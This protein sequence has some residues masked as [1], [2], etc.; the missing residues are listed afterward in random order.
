MRRKIDRKAKH[1][2]K[3]LHVSNSTARF[4]LA[5]SF[6]WH[7]FGCSRSFHLSVQL[8]RD[9]CWNKKTKQKLLD[10]AGFF[11][12]GRCVLFFTGEKV[13]KSKKKKK[14]EFWWEKRKKWRK[15]KPMLM[16][17]ALL[18]HIFAQTEKEKYQEILT[19]SQSLYCNDLNP[20]THLDFSMVKERLEMIHSRS[21]IELA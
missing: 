20:Q 11:I 6:A 21:L 2:M 10:S 5:R 4:I 17:F 15:M 19:P 7:I 18:P 8:T 3:F 9:C 12:L 13:K 16:L 14:S 1:K